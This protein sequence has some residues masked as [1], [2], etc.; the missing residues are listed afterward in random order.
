VGEQWGRV[1]DDGTVYLRTEDGERVVGQYP[2]ATP[3]AALAYF[4]RKYDDLA[5]QV[6][7][8][9]Q[10]V[11]AGHVNAGQAETSVARLTETIAQANAVGD[12]GALTARLTAIT[13]VARQKQA[14]TDTAAAQR[15]DR[16]KVEREALVV[17]AEKIAE[18][19][20]ERIHWKHAGDR[21]AELFETWKAAQRQSRL[22]KSDEDS[23]WHRFSHARTTFD[24]KRRHHFAA[25][26]E[27]R[28][29]AR[30]VKEKLVSQAE[31]LAA[32]TDWAA[33]S[34]AFRDL[35]SSWK[36]AGRA[37]ADEVLWARFKTAQD[38]FFAARSAAN[39]EQDEQLRGNLAA[40]EALLAQAERLVP[41]TDLTAA[42]LALRDL[43]DKWEA[44]GKVPRADLGR[45]DG[46]LR[47]VEQAVRDAE[48]ERWAR[49]NPQ[50]RGR[51]QDA[52]EKLEAALAG[53]ESD[54]R[55]ATEKGDARAVS[56]AE[57]SIAARRLWLDQARQV[58][59]D[60]DA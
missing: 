36:A 59:E 5:A 33:G 17:E 2:G 22:A 24:R 7:L 53:H 49:S 48:Q 57:Q 46:R 37:S 29:G 31:A 14:L 51:A 40:K 15:R 42:R 10:R 21:L 6:G 13:G 16:A 18:Q 12:L 58:L 55:R 8:L 45:I 60:F 20:P 56:E 38:A 9:E 44:A 27:Q 19:D 39:A 4:V 32:S 34:G 3:E 23:L 26:E 35:M 28:E 1:D 11:A 43:Q 50:A 25:L 54:L 41:V 47:A 30:V 52:V